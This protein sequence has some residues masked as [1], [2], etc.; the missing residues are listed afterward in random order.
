MDETKACAPSERF[1]LSLETWMRQECAFGLLKKVDAKRARVRGEKRRRTPAQKVRIMAP[2]RSM[3]DLGL[4]R[5]P[6]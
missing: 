1:N 6:G 3:E 5:S 2:A 4:T